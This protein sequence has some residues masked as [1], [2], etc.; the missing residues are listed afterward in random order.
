MRGFR[1]NGW[2][3]LGIILSV[4][5][6]PIGFVWASKHFGPPDQLLEWPFAKFCY[7]QQGKQPTPNYARCDADAQKWYSDQFDLRQIEIADAERL[8]PWFAFVPIPIVW[9]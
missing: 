3:R 4:V 1:L 7:E 6:I 5:W 9:L 8:P 2:Q